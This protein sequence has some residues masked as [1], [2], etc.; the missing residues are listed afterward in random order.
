M[1]KWI[2]KKS[3]SSGAL[4]FNRKKKKKK[5]PTSTLRQSD[6]LPHAQFTINGSQRTP[7]AK[8][9]LTMGTQR[10]ALAIQIGKSMRGDKKRPYQGVNDIK[11][12]M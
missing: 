4:H 6:G 8:P 10:K 5:F 7:K 11:D 9:N 3:P 1:T 12:C 2:S